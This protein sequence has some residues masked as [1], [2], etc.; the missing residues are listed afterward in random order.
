MEKNILPKSFLEEWKEF[1]S[2]HPNVNFFQTPEFVDLIN[3]V[4]NYKADVIF[5]LEKNKI[6]GILVYT[7]QKEGSDIKGYFTNKEVN[8]NYFRSFKCR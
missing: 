3:S 1:V 2:N 8:A 4:T 6:K 7:E 5:H